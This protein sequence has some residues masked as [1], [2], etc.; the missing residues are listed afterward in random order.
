MILYLTF[1]DLPSGIYS[2]QVIDVVK[3]MQTEMKQNVELAAFIS[4]RNYSKNKKKILA[5]L[6]NAIVMPMFPGVHRWRLNTGRLKKLCRKKNVRMIIGRSVLPTQLALRSGVEKVIYDGRGAIN[7]EWNE[8]KVVRN[9]KLLEDIPD[10]ER[11]SVLDAAFRIA[12][13]EKLIQLWKKEYQYNSD[14]H[15]IIPCTLNIAFENVPFNEKT[16]ADARLKLGFRKDDIAFVY[17]GSL[18]GWQSFQLLIDF[19]RPQLQRPNAKLLLLSSE[20]ENVLKLKNEFPGKV[21]HKKVGSRLV[22]NYLIA[23]D[24]G[25]LI[26]EKSV[27]NQVASP[28]KFAEYL[29]CGLKVI[30]S[31]QLGDCTEFVNKNNLGHIYTEF[32]EPAKLSLSQK[33]TIRLLALSHFTKKKFLAHFEKI[34]SK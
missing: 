6:P 17:S 13:S 2:S 4:I 26:R 10:L 31:D 25:L 11:S 5:E 3:F 27:T 24:Y 30:I 9:K 34:L 19:M 14:Q 22:P 23:A 12:V 18:A 29:A 28:V 33:Q 32:A 1:N 20:D 7:A 8:Y 15:V 16:I 21:V